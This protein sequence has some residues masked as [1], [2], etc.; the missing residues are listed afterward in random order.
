MLFALLEPYILDISNA[1][2]KKRT[3]DG[4]IA[5]LNDLRQNII[6]MHTS[7]YGRM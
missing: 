5:M 2:E 3:L 1:I 6:S 7:L 4:K